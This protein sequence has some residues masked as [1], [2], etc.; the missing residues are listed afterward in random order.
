[1][2]IYSSSTSNI[3][4][5][6]I[7]TNS[8]TRSKSK[9]LS[10]QSIYNKINQ[11]FQESIIDVK[12]TNHIDRMRILDDFEV[13]ARRNKISNQIKKHL[14]KESKRW[15]E[16][17]SKYKENRQ[18]SHRQL[19]QKLT[20]KLKIKDNSNQSKIEELQRLKEESS[21]AKKKEIMLSQSN[22][23]SKIDKHQ[24]SIE[25][26]RQ[27]LERNL[28]KK[29]ARKIE[30]NRKHIAK[31]RD[32]MEKKLNR[33]RKR[34]ESCLGHVQAL[35]ELRKEELEEIKKQHF[36]NFYF[37]M[38]EQKKSK[39]SESNMRVDRM[40]KNMSSKEKN[41]KLM[42]GKNYQTMQKIK[43]I[44]NNKM[45]NAEVR[46][47]ELMYKKLIH[48]KRSNENSIRRKHRDIERQQ[49]NRET[50]IKQL[51]FIKHKEG[52]T[53]TSSLTHEKNK[54]HQIIYQM[55]IN[56]SE[57]QLNFKKKLNIELDKSLYKLSDEEK[58]NYYLK[59]KYEE[60]EKRRK[61]LELLE[62]K[63]NSD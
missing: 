56:D 26:D 28:I 15:R 9:V 5:P 13:E 39:Q 53:N 11:T 2:S 30:L 20:K 38:Q 23:K 34:H 36:E 58:R 57:N 63:K 4:L 59:L 46:N 14:Q 17:L 37:F 49:T 32:S 27:V 3:Y 18:R 31:I 61:E 6:D 62:K 35:E 21:I 22:S 52:L 54:L 47:E 45:V 44:V 50:L 60:A 1:M 19:L 8:N 29:S 12:K 41:L 16:N 24:K 25:K 43:K 48:V 42:K 40:E 51:S 33:S 7:K 10:S 55:G